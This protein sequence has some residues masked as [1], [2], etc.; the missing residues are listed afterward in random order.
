MAQILVVDDE[1]DMREAM[2]DVLE[3][4]LR[5]DHCL[6]ASSGA[7]ALRILRSE[8]VDVLVSDQRM[9]GMTGLQLIAEVERQWPGL[10][11]ILVTGW[12]WDT[13]QE[14]GDRV[15]G[16]RILQKPF[17]ASALLQ[18]V[19]EALTTRPLLA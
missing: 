10:P 16:V 8:R 2:Q 9:P 17:D 14:L 12:A 19:R 1:P 7:E 18:E 11:H 4:Y 15:D 3:E 13:M 5:G 6:L